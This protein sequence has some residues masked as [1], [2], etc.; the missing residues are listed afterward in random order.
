MFILRIQAVAHA[1]DGLEKARVA[2][3]FFDG[4]AQPADMHIQGAGIAGVFGVPHLAEQV[5]RAPGLRPGVP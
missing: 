1:A 2:R 5:A 4:L 3:V